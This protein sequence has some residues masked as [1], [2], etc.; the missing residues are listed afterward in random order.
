MGQETYDGGTGYDTLLLAGGSGNVVHDLRSHIISG[1]EE[2][3]FGS[4][5]E[6]S[7]T[8]IAT[9]VQIQNFGSSGRIDGDSNDAVAERLQ[10]HLES[11]STFVLP[12]YVSF[13]GWNMTSDLVELIAGASNSTIIGSVFN[14]VIRGNSGKDALFGGGAA[15]LILG[16]AGNDTLRGDGGNDTLDG[17]TGADE[18]IGGAGSDSASYASATLSLSLDLR[19]GT[20]GGAAVSDT[21]RSI[22]NIVGTNFNDYIYGDNGQ[23][24][25][26]GGEGDD[27]LRGHNGHD[28]L[29]GGTGA[30][31]L[32]GGSGIDFA[33][34]ADASDR[35]N[36]DLRSRGTFGDA[37]N[38]TFTS[39]ENVTGTDY[40]D[41]IYGDVANNAIYGD[42][43]NDT[44]RGRSGADALLGGAGIDTASYSGAAQRVNLDLRSQGTSGDALGD[45]FLSIENVI[46]SQFDDY[47]YGDDKDNVIDGGDGFDRL[48]GHNGNDTL[49]GGAGADDLHGGGGIDTASYETA[50]SHVSLDLRSRGTSGDALNDTFH[51]IENVMASKFDDYVY[52]DNGQ[53][54][55]NGS[56]GDD[57][58]RGHNG[59]DTLIGGTGADD[60]NGGSGVDVASYAGAAGRVNLDLRSRGTFGDAANDTFTSIEN[61]IGTD[62][63]DYVYGDAGTDEL[64]GG[65]GADLF[66]FNRGSETDVI[67]DYQDDVDIIELDRALIASGNSAFSY[68]TQVGANVQFD[69]DAQGLLLVENATLAQLQDDVTVV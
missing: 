68:A 48:R 26:I 46:T 38:D 23:N 24:L 56:D 34:Y 19:S 9:A 30:D 57:R 25:L 7:R 4:L 63:N 64:R 52:G 50:Q 45:T 12:S 17:G 29:V 32:N 27:Q 60:L 69:F 11:L 62:Y 44:L 66:V 40:D 3:E 61:V 65:S 18:L 28:T 67:K 37:A 10:I 14:D 49:I 41:Y 21:F 47:V 2:I 54:M 31:D 35:V 13:V 58:L 43:G 51:A 22:E 42:A 59:H 55:L 5:S 6:G 33:S 8:V 16:S 15:D 39:I 53:N 1:V 20:F 36:L